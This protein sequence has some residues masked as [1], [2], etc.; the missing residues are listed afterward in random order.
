MDEK[1]R[2][3]SEAVAW[4]GRQAMAGAALLNEAVEVAIL[5]EMLRPAKPK[6]GFPVGDVD[7]LARSTLDALTGVVWRDDVLV[8][9]LDA[10][11]QY[12]TKEAGAW[13]QIKTQRDL[14]EE[15]LEI[16]G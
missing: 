16:G 1:E 10:A 3:W 9:R 13:I 14:D 15:S 6:R 12:T 2:P 8:T 11:K 4:A 5:F 7:K